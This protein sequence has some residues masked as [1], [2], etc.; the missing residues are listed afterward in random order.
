MAGRTG[1]HTTTAEVAAWQAQTP[2][3]AGGDKY[4]VAGDVSTN[5]PGDWTRIVANKTAFNANPAGDRYTNYCPTCA[6]V[7]QNSAGAY[8]PNTVGYKLRDAAFYYL[9]ATAAGDR[10]TTL[11]NVKQELLWHANNAYLDFSDRTRWPENGLVDVNPGFV[12]AEWGVRMMYAYDYVKGGLSG[13]EQTTIKNWFLNMARYMATNY[14]INLNSLFVNRAA[15]NYTLRQSTLNIQFG[16]NNTKRSDPALLYYGGPMSHYVARYYNN[17]RDGMAAFVG[18]AGVLLNDAGLIL[19]GKRYVQEY[20][21]FSI[22]PDSTK[23]DFFRGISEAKPDKG[24][25]YSGMSM[26]LALADALA[27]YGDTSLYTYSTSEGDATPVSVLDRTTNG[28][29]QKNLLMQMKGNLNL[30]NHVGSA[31]Y[32]STTSTSDVNK[33]ID[34][35]DAVKGTHYVNYLSNVAANLYYQDS[36]LDQSAKRTYGGAGG[37]YPASPTDQGAAK[38]YGY[39]GMYPGIAFMFLGPGINVFATPPA[40]T[41]QTITFAQP[42]A[43]TYGDGTFTVAAV[44]TS[45][46]AVSYTS[47]NTAVAT[48]HASTGL[49]TVLTAGTTTLTASQAGN[50][51][52]FPALDVAR[53]LTV[54]KKAQTI[55]FA[56]L[57][58]LVSTEPEFVLT[59]SATSSLPVGFDILSGPAQMGHD[60]LFLTGAA[61]IVSVRSFQGGNSNYL[62]AQPVI[63]TFTV[64][65]ASPPSVTDLLSG[66]TPTDTNRIATISSQQRLDSRRWFVLGS[67]VTGYVPRKITIPSG[68]DVPDNT[69]WGVE[70]W[71]RDAG[72]LTL[73]A[74]FD[75]KGNPLFEGIV[76]DEV[77][78]FDFDAMM[79]RCVG[80]N[81][82]M[83]IGGEAIKVEGN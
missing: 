21:K 49:V 77:G 59:G 57:P 25:N 43:K 75:A 1:L 27:R 16:L 63:R 38:S 68:D 37:V 30:G 11:A 6:P 72:V 4:A 31:K 19:S 52:F 47:S 39:Y 36:Y 66:I 50:G 53:T 54:N 65:V 79:F 81:I 8:D 58:D 20:L 34:W 80:K 45:A 78:A 10:A 42:A 41:S 29:T 18:I 74:T 35:D 3:F 7:P 67:P 40:K 14:D 15:G 33:R 44:S 76:D 26:I 60:T 12:I 71:V 13:G 55:T 56:V 24:L 28:S 82:A 51:S 48:I 9:I 83:R 70:M 64:T 23:S 69:V 5:S 32:S 22:Y 17:R 61:G 46:L 2:L 62:A 73:V